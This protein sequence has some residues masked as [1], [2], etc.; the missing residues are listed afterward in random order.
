[1]STC[2]SKAGEYSEHV[3]AGAPELRALVDC[4]RCGARYDVEP[5]EA[6]VAPVGDDVTEI[7]GRLFRKIDALED[8]NKALSLENKAL[9]DELAELKTAHAA[10]PKSPPTHLSTPM[11]VSARRESVGFK[12]LDDFPVRTDPIL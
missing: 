9:R 8:E 6:I 10:A 5:D 3:P 7:L 2:I 11:V 4:E 12:G 1:M